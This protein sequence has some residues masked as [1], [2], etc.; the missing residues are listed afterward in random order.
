MQKV[1]SSSLFSRLRKNLRISG[2]FCLYGRTLEAESL[3]RYRPALPNWVIRRQP[4]LAGAELVVRRPSS[5]GYQSSL[6][7]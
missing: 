4:H 6:R 3:L 7:S 1:E 2:G 5:L